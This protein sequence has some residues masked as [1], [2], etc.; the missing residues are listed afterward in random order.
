MPVRLSPLVRSAIALVALVAT[1]LLSTARADSG[2]PVVLV[3]GDSISAGYGL[4]KGTG[5]V[6]LLAARTM[7]SA[8]R[9]AS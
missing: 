7:P 8:F 4:T 9:G 3:V 5:W 6:D 1:M 2:A